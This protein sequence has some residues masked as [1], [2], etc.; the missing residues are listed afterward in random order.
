MS[1]R[2]DFKNLVVICVDGGICSQLSFV[3]FG[4]YL[5]SVLGDAVRVKYDLL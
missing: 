4:F 2:H 1:V 3:A 5:K